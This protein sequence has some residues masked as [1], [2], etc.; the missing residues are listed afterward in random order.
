M[1]QYKISLLKLSLI[2]TVFSFLEAQDSL[3]IYEES[4]SSVFPQSLSNSIEIVDLNND[5]I[6]DIIITGY[7]SSRFGIFLDIIKGNSD[8]RHWKY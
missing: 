3:F 2:W 8:R 4:F 7:D 5:N 6:N 1:K